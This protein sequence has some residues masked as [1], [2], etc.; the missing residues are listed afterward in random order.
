M[1]DN[2]NE[3][4]VKESDKKID[5]F[6]KEKDLK[7]FYLN[8]DSLLEN[9]SP[10]DP[11]MKPD[12]LKQMINI[13]ETRRKHAEQQLAKG[14]SVTVEREGHP[15]KTL[16]MPQIIEVI[17]QQKSQIQSD[18]LFDNLMQKLFKGETIC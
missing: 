7:D 16:N 5:D 8:L 17:K 11:G 3:K 12:V 13:E 6:V 4:F 10:G 15:P 2:A 14:M 1:L 9:Y 18:H